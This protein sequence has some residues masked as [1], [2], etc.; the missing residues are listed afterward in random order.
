M[1]ID[2]VNELRIRLALQHLNPR[3][4]NSWT[5]PEN[6]SLIRCGMTVRLAN[7]SYQASVR[8]RICSLGFTIFSA[9][10]LNLIYSGYPPVG[11]VLPEKGM[12]INNVTIVPRLR[13]ST[14]LLAQGLRHSLF[15]NG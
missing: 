10:E 13:S 14:L 15:K 11:G 1:N 9:I 5:L 12:F 8:T 3:P 7:I 2:L 6:P 4:G